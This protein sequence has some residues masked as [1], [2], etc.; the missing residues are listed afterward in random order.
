MND[1][2]QA[3]DLA[4]C[5]R[6]GIFGRAHSP[7]YPRPKSGKIYLVEGA[8]MVDPPF[9]FNGER[10]GLWLKDAPF[11]INNERVWDARRFRK[12]R[13]LSEEEHRE[14]IEELAADHRVTA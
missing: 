3:G 14:A 7:E 9:N 5:V 2:W 8:G 6:G 10:F 11:N 4:L 13:P 12:I 1:D